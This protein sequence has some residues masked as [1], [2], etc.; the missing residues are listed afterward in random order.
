MTINGSSV[1]ISFRQLKSILLEFVEEIKH[2]S[3][4]FV[5]GLK[6]ETSISSIVVA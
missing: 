3:K 2:G 6:L 4:D 1:F 5:K